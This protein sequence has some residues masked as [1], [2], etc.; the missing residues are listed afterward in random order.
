MELTKAKARSI[1]RARQRLDFVDMFVNIS[2]ASGDDDTTGLTP[3]QIFCIGDDSKFQGTE[4]GRQ[5]GHSFAFALDSIARAALEPRSMGIHISTDKWEAQKKQIYCLRII[6]SLSDAAKRY[7]KVIGEA[8]NRIELSNGSLIDFLACRPPRGADRASVY[9]DE[10]A[11]M[12]NVEQILKAGIGCTTHG[13]GYVR[14]G[15]THCGS[16]TEFY[17]IVRNTEDEWGNK[18]YES[19]RRNAFPWWSCHTLC[20]DVM[21][22][23]KEAPNMTTPERV[24]KFGKDNIKQIFKGYPILSDF[25]EE[26]E[27]MVVDEAH[28]FFP[29]ELIHRCI[30][31]KG[32]DEWY[33]YVPI[34]GKTP[35]CLQ[36][37][38]EAIRKLKMARFNGS[39]PG[40]LGV[41]MDIGR[42]VDKDEISIGNFYN[43]TVTLRLSIS[44]ADM[45]FEKKEEIWHHIQN[46]LE[47]VKGSLDATHGS[48]GHHMGETMFK[49]YGQ[50]SIAFEFTNN[51]KSEL[52]NGMKIKMEQNHFQMPEP[53]PQLIRQFHAIKKNVTIGGHVTYGVEENNEHHGDMFWSVAMLCG[54]FVTNVQNVAFPIHVIQQ[55]NKHRIPMRPNA[56][57]IWVPSPNAQK[58][59]I[60]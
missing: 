51:S 23:L 45:P 44:M 32:V 15:S 3:N 41:S 50:K 53:L 36:P 57:G 13:G 55:Q 22:A 8:K 5:Q 26:F 4:K 7:V 58:F 35:D 2:E 52:A 19:W 18:P 24:E 6:E 37:A 28:A 12:P 33:E 31:P 17:K 42:K 54:L 14:V 9:L 11:F 49:K 20:I 1:V 48:M 16:T 60:R 59:K 27:C 39:I 10:M 47:I 56:A 30:P 43:D 46:E 21:T 34:D 25:Q 29:L 40:E 38:K